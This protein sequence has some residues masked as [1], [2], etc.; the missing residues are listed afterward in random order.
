MQT[1][2][3]IISF[4]VFMLFASY[5]LMQLEDHGGVDDSL[6][7]YQLASDVWRVLYLKGSFEYLE[8]ESQ[9]DAELDRIDGMTGLC[10]YIGGQRATSEECRGRQTTEHVVSIK[11]IV[12]MNGV[13][14]ERTLSIYVAGK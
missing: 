5:V 12:L 10:T 3:A 14:R 11:R 9:L 2:E 13:P 4:A 7:R 1:L 6:Y 8:D